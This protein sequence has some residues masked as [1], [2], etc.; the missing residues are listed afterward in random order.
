MLARQKQ[1]DLKT[2]FRDWVFKDPERREALVAIFNEKFNSTRP[3]EYDGSHITFAGMNAEITLDEHQVNAVARGIYGGNELLAHEPGAGKSFVMA[4]IAMEGKRIGVC[5]K[6]LI[7]VP[8]H[9]TGQMASEFLRLYPNANILV[10]TDRTFEPKNRKKFCSKIATG[11][12]DAVILGHAQFGK[13]QLSMENQLKY[14]EEQFNLLVDAIAEAKEAD[15]GYFTVKQMEK[16]KSK[17]KDKL[18]ELYK[19]KGK[20]TVITF[21]ELGADKLFVDEADLFKELCYKGSFKKGTLLYSAT[22]LFAVHSEVFVNPT[23]RRIF[24]KLVGITVL[25]QFILCKRQLKTPKRWY[26]RLKFPTASTQHPKVLRTIIQYPYIP[27][28]V[29][30][31]IY[32]TTK[33]GSFV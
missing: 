9:L 21:E 24:C 31:K 8:K 28:Q 33:K 1:E 26:S 4:A 17:V 18:D 22:A 27:F 5:S 20:D 30:R 3:R 10:A 29:L 15:G 6:S 32:Q 2:V 11:N 16:V 13:I 25:F 12:Y 7:T 14:Y 19:D 23:E